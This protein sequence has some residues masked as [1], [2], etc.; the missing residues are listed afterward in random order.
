MFRQCTAFLGRHDE[1]SQEASAI[2]NVVVLVVL[3]QVEDVLTQQRRLLRIHNEQLG[4]QVDD[5]QLHYF[6]LTKQPTFACYDT[7]YTQYT[8]LKL[9]QIV[10]KNLVRKGLGHLSQN[11]GSNLGNTIRILSY[12]PQNAGLGKRHGDAVDEASQVGD[13]FLVFA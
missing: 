5:L 8:Q 11:I 6:I 12:Q 1:V 9:K 4:S 7:I 2:T 3:G 10:F 13:D